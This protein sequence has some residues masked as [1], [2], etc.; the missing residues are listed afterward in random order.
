MSKSYSLCLTPER[1]Q[2]DF[3]DEPP[4]DEGSGEEEE[5]REEEEEENDEDDD[6]ADFHDA[7]EKLTIADEASRTVAVSA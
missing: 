6:A 7:I 4:D 1:L 5:E 2:L 3:E